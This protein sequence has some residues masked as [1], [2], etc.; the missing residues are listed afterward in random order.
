MAFSS[1][2]ILLV[3]S[4]QAIPVKFLEVVEANPRTAVQPAYLMPVV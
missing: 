4:L 1:S 3:V 2:E